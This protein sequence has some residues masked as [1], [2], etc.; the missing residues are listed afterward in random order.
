VSF[1]AIECV[2]APASAGAPGPMS[3]QPW[4]ET[5]NSAVPFAYPSSESI[6]RPTPGARLKVVCFGGGT[7]LSTLLRSWKNFVAPRDQEEPPALLDRLT[8]VVAVSDNGGSSGRLREEFRILPPGDIRNCL[9]ALADEQALLSRMFQF[10]FAAG[11]GL[12]G[13]SFGNLFLTALASLTSDF[14]EAIKLACSLLG[15]RGQVLPATNRLVELGAE[16]NNGRFV[17]GETTITV[18]SSGIRRLHLIPADAEPLPETLAAIAEADLITVGP[19]SLYTSLI[20]NLLVKGIPQAIRASRALKAY[21]CNLMTQP[22]ETLGMSAADHVRSIYRHAGEGLF[23]CVLVN[24]APLPPELLAKY[25]ESGAEPVRM[26][27][28]KLAALGVD[29]IEGAY[30]SA[31]DVARH[32]GEALARQ[33]LPRA[34]RSASYE[35]LAP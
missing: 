6:A 18:A 16:L 9:V 3:S 20:P 5:T 11:D 12:N 13:H 31:G 30:V 15:T 29:V 27:R 32:S 34:T 8:A 24:Q 19:G 23:E 33:L 14:V 28:D 35:A 10:R 1:P 26:D 7:G 17:I 21:I 25:A 2:A 22:N 4:I